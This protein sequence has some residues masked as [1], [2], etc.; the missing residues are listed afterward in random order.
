M[1]CAICDVELSS[2]LTS[3]CGPRRS[4]GMRLIIDSARVVNNEVI[5][6]KQRL[7]LCADCANWFAD[8]TRARRKELKK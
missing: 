8:A 4:L 6:G 2:V 1:H 5:E 7:W 3:H